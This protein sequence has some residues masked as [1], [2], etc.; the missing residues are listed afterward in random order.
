MARKVQANSF[1]KGMVKSLAK[2][3]IPNSSYKD[4]RNFRLGDDKENAN[5]ALVNVL[6]NDVALT[7]PSSP[8]IFQI[9]PLD[10]IEE[11]QAGD[12]DFFSVESYAGVISTQIN[13]LSGGFEDY[14]NQVTTAVSDPTSGFAAL[15]IKAIKTSPRSM[16]IFS[17]TTVIISVNGGASQYTRTDQTASVQTNLQIIGQANLRNELII[18]TTNN[19]LEVGG[20]GQIWKVVYNNATQKYDINLRYSHDF[21]G[22]STAYPI[23]AIARYENDE[24][25]RTYW[26]DFYNNVRTLNVATI[27]TSIGVNL[28][29]LDLAPSVDFTRPVISKIQT[30]GSLKAGVYQYFYTLSSESGAKT[31]VSPTSKMVSLVV[32]GENG[33]EWSQLGE[34]NGSIP[35]TNTNKSIQIT[36]KDIDVTYTNIEVGYLYYGD[37]EANPEIFIFDTLQVPNT[38]ELIVAHSGA[39]LTSIVSN[40]EYKAFG[41]P[42]KKAKTI[43]HQD[44]RLIVGNVETPD[45]SDLK[46]NARA[47]RFC[48]TVTGFDAAGN[49]LASLTNSLEIL[50]PVAG[51]GSNIYCYVPNL[52]VNDT[53]WNQED[54]EADTMPSIVRDGINPYNRPD[55]ADDF[56]PF[57]WQKNGTILGGSGPHVSYKFITSADANGPT[58]GYK[59][60]EPSDTAPLLSSPTN[61]SFVYNFNNVNDEVYEIKEGRQTFKNSLYTQNFKGYVPGEVYRFGI[62]LYDLEGNPGFVNWIGDI[63]FPE[64]WEIR[65]N[66][67]PDGLNGP[68]SEIFGELPVSIPENDP[69]WLYNDGYNLYKS[70][71]TEIN[72]GIF[73][74]STDQLGIEFSIQLPGALGSKV[75]GYEI[76]R[77]KREIGDKTK[78]ASGLGTL[79]AKVNSSSELRLFTGQQSPQLKFRLKNL[80]GLATQLTYPQLESPA[81]YPADAGR[82]IMFYSPAFHFLDETGFSVNDRI[83]IEGLASPADSPSFPT[84]ITNAK[85][86]NYSF[87]FNVSHKHLILKDT[88]LNGDVKYGNRTHSNGKTTIP[89][90]AA[91]TIPTGGQL[92]AVPGISP[93]VRF[94]NATPELADYPASTLVTSAPHDGVEGTLLVINDDSVLKLPFLYAGENDFVG[95]Y[96]IG[97]GQLLITY[98]REVLEQYGGNTQAARANNFYIKTGSFVSIPSTAQVFNVF[99]LKTFGGDIYYMLYDITRIDGIQDTAEKPL[100]SVRHGYI[101]PCFSPINLDYRK[102]RHF[103]NKALPDGS[104]PTGSETEYLHDTFEYEKVYDRQDDYV[105]FIGRQVNPSIKN[106]FDNRVHASNGKANG[107]LIDNWRQFPV[108]L[109]KDVDGAYGPINKLLQHNDNVYYFQNAASGYLLIN[110]RASVSTSTAGGLQMGFGDVIH[111]FEYISTEIGCF[112]QWVPIATADNIYIID[113][114]LKS[115]FSIQGKQITPVS[116]M[117]S[118][119]PE[120][121]KQLVGNILINDN[122]LKFNGIHTGWNTRFNEVFFT[123]FNQA[124]ITKT[125]FTDS[126]EANYCF[127]DFD[128]TGLL[129]RAVKIKT[130]KL[131]GAIISPTNKIDIVD[132]GGERCTVTILD[133]ATDS[134]YTYLKIAAFI[135]FYAQFN[136]ALSSTGGIVQP[137]YIEANTYFSER[138]CIYKLY[139]YSQVAETLV[140]NEAYSMFTN[141]LD[142]TPQIY[143]NDRLNL[144]AP[145][146]AVGKK[147]YQYNKGK[148]GKFFDAT[149]PSTLDLIINSEIGATKVFENISF[150]TETFTNTSNPINIDKKTFT[151]VRFFT[152]YQNTD[153]ITLDI[154]NKDSLRRVE[155]EFQA[156]I[157][158]NVVKQSLSNIDIFDPT[159][160]DPSQ[161]F[162]E[163]LRDKYMT[164]Q[165]KFSNDGDYRFLLHYFKTFYNV[166]VR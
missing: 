29:F 165:L 104:Y 34:V 11:P 8:S 98:E 153:W 55:W 101:F 154:T 47:Y 50:Y 9:L 78:V 77:V 147:I 21:I 124:S 123:F 166:S 162:K 14:F 43:T 134:T 121:R 161:K 36:I 35:G 129:A 146:P 164:I 130:S 136:G 20:N 103:L 24:I 125:L 48:N 150:F 32:T 58:Y 141:F 62:V 88:T 149:F 49:S 156:V 18:F 65:A 120:F 102:G 75:S 41:I 122:P 25:Q 57:K 137:D 112:H 151:Q 108:L 138:Q 53:F 23:E 19:E 83:R 81:S 152:D 148:Y 80:T 16:I 69:R 144:L 94:V 100:F 70:R 39:E 105:T 44:N 155:R 74:L 54:P 142:A 135:G 111:D 6:G 110:P 45:N 157:P 60:Q 91:R 1:E 33:T 92:S 95:P 37:L 68:G 61:L 140:Y 97:N 28:Q 117:A 119:N 46:F 40:T 26:T 13:L 2:D 107:E 3:R 90:V 22:F 84:A 15:K 67:G 17:E 87:S 127:F 63:K 59:Y 42:F 159:N 76:V 126:D 30:G 115:L 133:V 52:N 89:L 99:D 132:A 163:R 113:T 128:N 31:R 106:K 118:M 66:M 5:G 38:G 27:D 143:L 160:L 145:S 93:P 79:V 114:Q 73:T 139:I 116:E 82:C 7:I 12:T 10:G 96:G 109:Y 85:N 56:L 64:L 131:S 72:S 86:K 4:A 71:A 158:R 51:A